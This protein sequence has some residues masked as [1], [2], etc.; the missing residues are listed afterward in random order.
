[1]HYIV[2]QITNKV[3]GKIYIGIHR[4]N[5]VNDIYMGSGVQIQRAIKKYGIDQFEKSILAHCENEREMFQ[6]ERELVTEEFCLRSD[7]Y[8]VKPGGLGGGAPKGNSYALGKTWKVTRPRSA[9][10]C[11]HRRKSQ[12]GKKRGHYKKL[13][14]SQ[15][16]LD[17]S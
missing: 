5:D 8:N 10:Y 17:G 16:L 1:M 6:I 15:I 3:N 2:Y 11:E 14:K 7:T 13:A 12:T 4:T 9:E